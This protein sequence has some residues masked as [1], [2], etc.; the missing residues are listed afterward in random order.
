MIPYGPRPY[1]SFLLLP[2]AKESSSRAPLGPLLSR[3]SSGLAQPRD[4]SR[5][6]LHEPPREVRGQVAGY[7][8]G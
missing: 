8:G 2:H 1:E 7:L 5:H 4:D 6:Q 3:A